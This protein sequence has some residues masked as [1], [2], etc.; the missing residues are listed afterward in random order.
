MATDAGGPEEGV[1][2]DAQAAPESGSDAAAEHD[3]DDG[4]DPYAFDEEEGAG[5]GPPAVEVWNDYD[6]S[7]RFVAVFPVGEDQGAR[8]GSVA[9][10]IIEPGKHT[11]LHSDNAE[12]IVYVADGTGEAFVS[13]RHIV[14]NPGEFVVLNEGIEHDIYANGSVALRFLSFFPTDE[15]IS[16]FQ[17]VIY[18]MGGNILSSKPPKP[19]V[20]ELDPENLP[21]DFPFDLSEL[22][23]APAGE[24]VEPQ[25]ADPADTEDPGKG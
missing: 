13:G 2:E 14:F 3:L 15:I 20:Q 11:G 21:E 6:P 23:L 18:P 22:G 12:E 10:Y 8:A 16:T 7:M 4:F 9:Y 1:E 17:Q 24:A 19:V 5:D 25:A